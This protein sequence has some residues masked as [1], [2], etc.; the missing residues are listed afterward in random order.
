MFCCAHIDLKRA[1][2]MRE[3]KKMRVYY[4][5]DP[6]IKQFIEKFSKQTQR[7]DALRMPYWVFVQDSNPI[8]LVAIGKEPV[9][10]IASPGTPMAIIHWIDTE[11]S[12][13]DIGNF[14]R[15]ALELATSKE[16]EYAISVF[17]SGEK[18]AIKQFKEIGF[19]DLDD[20]YKMVCRL[21]KSFKPSHELRFRQ[22]QREEMRQFIE[23]AE[24]FLSGSPDIML[25]KALEHFPELPD[26]FLSFH[27]SQERFY[28]AD[29][30]QQTIGVLDFNPNKG[31]VSNVGVDPRQRGRGYGRQI[32]L[33]ALQQLRNSGCKEAY[34]RV[35]VENKP[36]INLYESLG[37]KKTE[38]FR[39]LVWERIA[40]HLEG[41]S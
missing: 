36:A 28:F 5:K 15:Q 12:R 25:R 19:Q 4:H 23:V 40:N 30:D 29:K 3:I 17:P 26:E 20:S 24:R 10:L 31:L 39:T 32:M 6:E 11:Q 8:G 34:L 14:A 16:I 18:D 7:L 33:F 38:G 37:F 22:V 21:D 41:A 9:Q 35:H 2:S 27:Y 1:K 13:E